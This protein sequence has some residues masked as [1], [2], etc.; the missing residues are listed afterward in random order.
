MQRRDR[1]ARAGARQDDEARRR[2]RRHRLVLLGYAPEDQARLDHFGFRVEAGDLEE[3]VEVSGRDAAAFSGFGFVMPADAAFEEQV[4]LQAHEGECRA[5]ELDREASGLPG[6]ALHVVDGE[7]FDDRRLGER[8]ARVQRRG[9]LRFVFADL[10]AFG[11]GKR[12]DLGFGALFG[13]F[14]VDRQA[15]RQID[16]HVAHLAFGRFVAAEQTDFF[17]GLEGEVGDAEVGVP[18]GLGVEVRGRARVAAGGR[19]AR[20]RFPLAQFERRGER[21]QRGECQADAEDDKRAAA[22]EAAQREAPRRRRLRSSRTPCRTALGRVIHVCALVSAPLR[23]SDACSRA[24]SEGLPSRAPLRHANRPSNC[25]LSTRQAAP[26][27]GGDGH[28]GLVTATRR[29]D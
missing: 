19:V 1:L 26:P 25:G 16:A 12:V 10:A 3:L 9:A 6:E 28:G 21:R 18:G 13:G 24:I 4:A 11:A 22:S 20:A 2:A 14:R 27:P 8:D 5:L 15:R 29:G 23:V 17:F 7:F